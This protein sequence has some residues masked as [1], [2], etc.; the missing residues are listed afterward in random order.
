MRRSV[1]SK[2]RGSHLLAEYMLAQSAAGTVLEED[3]D[4]PVYLLDV[5]CGIARGQGRNFASDAWPSSAETLVE[6]LLANDRLRAVLDLDAETLTHLATNAPAAIESIKS[7]MESG[8]LEVVSG[9]WRPMAAVLGGEAALR[10]LLREATALRDSLGMR[11]ESYLTTA[12]DLFPQSP[13][14]LAGFGFR[15]VVVTGDEIGFAPGDEELGRSF[16]LRGPDGSEIAAALA[17]YGNTKGASNTSDVVDWSNERLEDFRSSPTGQRVLFRVHA[18]DSPDG[19]TIARAA[20]A[21]RD[22]VRFVTPREYFEGATPMT[23]LETAAVQM[24]AG[25]GF[26]SVTS[27][28]GST[29]AEQ[30]LL[31][32]ERLDALAY[33]M[34][35]ESA[36]M[37]LGQA[38]R[39]L[40]GARE[41]APETSASREGEKAGSAH[42][43]AREIA[44]TS[45]RFLASHVD[46]RDIEGRGLVVFNPSSWPRHEYMELT[47][48]G[49]G[50]RIT[51]GG[52]EV[53]SQV[54]DRRDGYVTVGFVA[55]APALGYRLLE[56]QH[57]K[58]HEVGAAPV[59]MPGSRFFSN[60]YYSAQIADD[61]CLRV[62]VADAPLVD[63][64]GYLTVWRDGRVHDSREGV[65]GIEAH[66]QG[67]VFD[68]Y[69]IEGH[70]AGMPCRQW[71]TF[72]RTLPRID[73]RTEIEFGSGVA[74]EALPG[75]QGRPPDDG[76]L[77]VN[78]RSPLC[79]LFVDSPF[80][81]GDAVEG[82]TAALSLTGLED[83][84]SKG[85]AVLSRSVAGYHFDAPDGVLKKVLAQR[86]S[87]LRGSRSWEWGIVRTISRIGA[88]R[89]AADYLLPCLGAFVTPHSGSLPPEGSFLKI[90]PDQALLSAMFV[91]QGKVYVRLWN[92]SSG[93]V[94]ASVGSGGPLSLRRC[95]LDLVD[96]GPAAETI[97]LP[98]W[99]VQTLRLA[100][101]GEMS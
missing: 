91:R 56:V 68:R 57:L 97:S 19:P 49:E 16:R 50:Y 25:R 8:R 98:P 90:G 84:Q 77:A 85:I 80:F 3:L 86:E 74:L 61:G 20:V 32:A 34:G 22:D 44:E 89:A 7:A 31:L 13:Q 72:Y 11:A 60:P 76:A 26:G 27:M 5:Y 35:K 71:M 55:E 29:E 33:A 95:S 1:E 28:P 14:I 12:E 64:A 75:N 87:R 78:L 92:P 52:R 47:L 4:R 2:R 59:A 65:S 39:E 24:P 66:R 79:R 38:W 15:R 99:G 48:G 73:L 100:G 23:L 40:L 10:H 41:E 42:R 21:A 18:V 88:T 67:P 96:E 17:V 81:V 37:D 83:E 54:V 94:D 36:E 82:R 63:A 101:A 58:P 69:L 46:S 6:S 30:A 93:E 43:S 51:H 45:A 53:L 70:V 62:E 9:F